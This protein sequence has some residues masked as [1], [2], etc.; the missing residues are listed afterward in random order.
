[1][2]AERLAGHSLADC[3][4]CLAALMDVEG[5]RARPR[6]CFAR[7]MPNGRQAAPSATRRNAL[8]TPR[9]WRVCKPNCPRTFAAATLWS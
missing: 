1:M 3:L 5:R 7:R 8:A 9:S 6:S 2:R 4:D